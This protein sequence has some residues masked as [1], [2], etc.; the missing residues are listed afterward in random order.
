[1]EHLLLK[2]ATTAIDQGT[3]EAVISTATIDRELDIVEPQAM[4]DALQK[5]VP[6]GKKVP[7][8]WNHGTDPEHIIGHIAP[9]SARVVNGEVSVT[10]WVDQGAQL[11]ADAWRLVKSGTL[12]F[13]FGYL[14]TSST[15]RADGGRHI[16][17]MDVFEVTA[18]HAPMNGDTRVLG[19]KSADERDAVL[20]EL[21]EVKDRLDTLEKSLGGAGLD[22]LLTRLE[23]ALEDQKKSVEV[24]DEEPPEAR[25]VDLL[26]RQADE[27]ALKHASGGLS[28]E[29]P[30]T[31]EP[32]PP[33]PEL[34]D[35]E[36]LKQQM[37]DGMLIH[38]N[39]AITD[40]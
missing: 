20:I 31:P 5:W 35:L 23:Q 30:P 40:E 21:Q 38:L 1:M 28:L 16:T 29:K 25:S 7:L 9:D 2:A 22:E 14:I 19:W 36:E 32:P 24:T 13:S 26:R 4:V 15:K 10:G 3:F 33:K 8:R 6:T 39:G 17:G 37:R 12:G 34:L 27:V 18:S 11:G